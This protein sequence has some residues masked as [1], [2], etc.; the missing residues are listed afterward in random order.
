M[1]TK[2]KELSGILFWNRRGK[3]VEKLKKPKLSL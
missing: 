1:L 3:L 2:Y